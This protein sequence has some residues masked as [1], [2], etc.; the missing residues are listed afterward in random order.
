VLDKKEVNGGGG[1]EKEPKHTTARSLV[2]YNT[3]KILSAQDT[4][5]CIL[6]FLKVVLCALPYPIDRYF[7][8]EY[9]NIWH[10]DCLS[11]KLF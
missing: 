2:D 3:F 5:G 1:D 6:K 7:L 10:K 8:E 11:Y 4:H 9:R